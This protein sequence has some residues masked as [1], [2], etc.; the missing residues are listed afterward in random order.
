MRAKHLIAVAAL[1]GAT[2]AG[3]GQ[4]HAILGGYM[5]DDPTGDLGPMQDYASDPPGG[6]DITATGED[7]SD[8][9]PSLFRPSLLLLIFPDLFGTNEGFADQGVGIAGTANNEIVPGTFIQ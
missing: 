6:G 4:A 9:G 2:L 5:F 1:V 8:F 3:L 7:V